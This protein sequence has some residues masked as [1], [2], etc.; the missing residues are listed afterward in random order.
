MSPYAQVDI[1][2]GQVYSSRYDDIYY[3][4]DD[5]PAESRHVF[6]A[7]ND[8]PMRWKDKPHF[9]I[10]ETGF[11]TGLNFLITMQAWLDDAA[12]CE[13]LDYFAIEAYPLRAAQLA[14]IHALWP[15]MASVSDA[16]LEQYPGRDSGCHSLTF[17][18]GRVQLH[19]IFDLLEPCLNHYQL[20]PDAWYLDGFSPSRN[21]SMWTRHALNSIASQS[22]PG[23]SLATF[24]AA[25]EVRRN[26]HDA[27]FEVHKR[28][29]F[30]RKREMLCARKAS[31]DQGS[32]KRQYYL[33]SAPWFA[34]QAARKPPKQVAIIGAG[35]AGA[36]SAWHLAQRGINV[37]VIEQRDRIAAAASGNLAG[38]IAPKLTASA[39]AEEAFYLAAFEYQ[40]RQIKA[41]NEC[42][43]AINFVPDGLLHLAHKQPSLSR[44]K[45]ICARE[46][47]PADLIKLIDANETSS[48]LGEKVAYAS[49]LINQA[50]SISPIQ[51]CQALLKHP[52]IKL[53]LSTS[54]AEIAYE[55]EHLQLSLSAGEYLNVDAL[56]LANGY[57]ASDF[58][59]TTPITPVRG[60]TSTARLPADQMLKH[61][62]RHAGYILNTPGQAQDVVFGASYVR[63]DHSDELRESET[64]HDL[65]ILHTSLPQLTDNL[66]NIK[67]GHAGVRATTTDRWPIV[68][69]LADVAFYQREYAD[70]HQGKQYKSYP[71]AH[72]QAGLYILSGLGSRG[73]TS[74]AYC[75]NLLTHTL[76]GCAPPAPARILHA[77]HPARFL[78]RKLYKGS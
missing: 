4:T 47:L 70:L 17:E 29:G 20:D 40:L 7:G 73:F 66:T 50:G 68:G 38:L 44:F 45:R 10:A 25:G 42:G 11:G 39:G 67:P 51:L 61:A 13:T 48:L 34:T 37:V 2:D 65:D 62:L 36:Q 33:K 52:N 46:D 3:N 18:Q 53:E 41:L 16:L 76:L 72:Y 22:R 49:L 71:A 5:G 27:G 57:Q 64:R 21:P 14:E 55:D 78:V 28:T 8:L 69:P 31:M 24:T 30:G 58:S 26:L 77:L 19:L 1:K 15:E 56:V 23:T 12:H 6:L 54:L 32:S 9:C 35:I 75:A 59:N 60:Q 43:H 74:A 63:G